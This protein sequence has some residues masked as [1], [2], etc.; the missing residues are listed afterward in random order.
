M[1]ARITFQTIEQANALATAWTRSTLTGHTK[2]PDGKGG[3]YVDLYNVTEERKEWVNE[4]V[5]NLNKQ[6]NGNK[7]DS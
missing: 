5:A 2:G 7:F 3:F 6:N 4:Q 1:K